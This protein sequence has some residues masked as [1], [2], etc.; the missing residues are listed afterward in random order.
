MID[1]TIIIQGRCEDSQLKLWIENHSNLP[2]VLSTWEDY[3][4]DLNFPQNWKIIKAPYP[5]R[6]GN[7][8]NLDYQVQSTL[9]ALNIINTKY[10]IKVRAD[11]YWYNVQLLYDKM[12]EDVS[13]I[14]LGSAFF[15]KLDNPQYPFHISDHIMCGTYENIK[16]LFNETKKN[17]INNYIPCGSPECIMGYSYVCN[18]EN[19]D[20]SKMRDYLTNPWGH[21]IKKYFNIIDV[22][23]LS[24]FLLN[25]KH[26]D[27]RLYWKNYWDHSGCIN[28]FEYEYSS[29]IDRT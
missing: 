17:L 26:L 18:K 4:I 21:F 16:L 10:V 6:F 22:N 12:K 15:R 7:Y 20:K 13:K 29:S 1:C 24:P 2:I 27:K 25:Q 11:E 19:F 14:L 23:Q 5:I 28:S 9:N 3:E 8:Q